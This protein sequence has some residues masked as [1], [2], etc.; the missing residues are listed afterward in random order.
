[1]VEGPSKMR[2][3]FLHMVFASGH[4]GHHCSAYTLHTYEHRQA[5]DK[6]D[7]NNVSYACQSGLGAA[8]PFESVAWRE[9][10]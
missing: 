3:R 2:V 4:T 6:N 5:V 8:D 1:M 10:P 7:N 9:E